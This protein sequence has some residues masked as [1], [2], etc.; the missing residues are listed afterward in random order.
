MFQSQP[1]RRPTVAHVARGV[2]TR[3]DLSTAQIQDA[4]DR[5]HARDGMNAVPGYYDW[6][7]LLLGASLRGRMLDVGCGT[8]G[9]L[10]AAAARGIATAGL[11]I[12]DVAIARARER[13]PGSELHVGVAERLPFADGEF[14]VVSCLG[15]LEHF[16]DPTQAIRE[17]RRVTRP[18]GRLLIAVPNSRHTMTPVI[19]LRQW[20]F[21]GLSQPVERRATRSE[22]QA[23]LERCGLRVTAIHKDNNSYI[24][25]RVLQALSRVLGRLT[26]LGVCYQFVF[27][28]RPD[29]EPV[30]EPPIS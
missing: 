20:L 23:L 29:Q 10:A 4:Y 3:P 24:P 16:I 17:M 14:D 25:T 12:S 15:S 18:D 28:A 13:V 27:V 9:M 30:G 22:W 26:P 21:P 11:D 8:G 19:A 1:D 2:D 6:L 5:I 7:L